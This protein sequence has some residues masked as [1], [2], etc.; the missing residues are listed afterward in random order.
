MLRKVGIDGEVICKH[1]LFTSWGQQTRSPTSS[2]P[3]AR[4]PTRSRLAAG[5]SVKE[6]RRQNLNSQ[7]DVQVI[8]D[9]LSLRWKGNE[10]KSMLELSHREPDIHRECRRTSSP[11]NWTGIKVDWDACKIRCG[12]DVSPKFEVRNDLEFKAA[13]IYLAKASEFI[14]NTSASSN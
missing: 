9:N 2:Q 4:R 6:A 7:A 10:M 5:F 11:L 13:G 1:C 8:G 12:E 3:S 14:G